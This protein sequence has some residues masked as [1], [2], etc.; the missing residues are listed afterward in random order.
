MCN[1]T[2][3]YFEHL[4]KGELWLQYCPEC[5]RYIFYPRSHCPG[6]WSQH[7]EWHR[8]QGKGR[9]YSYSV[10]RVSSLG[11][12]GE[13]PYIY[14]LITL[15]EGV[16]MASRIVDCGLQEA[17]VDMPVEMTLQTFG[18]QMMPVFRPVCSR[19]G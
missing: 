18:G 16:R 5:Q 12:D 14:A 4:N 15:D 3:F 17:A 8:S 10:I 6:C 19:P 7:W 2:Q 1:P 13:V 11:G 9:I